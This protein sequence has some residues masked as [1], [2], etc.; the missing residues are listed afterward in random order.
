MRRASVTIKNASEKESGAM[1]IQIAPMAPMKKNVSVRVTNSS[2]LAK[3]VLLQRSYVI[4]KK[5]A[6]MD[7]TKGIVVSYLI[8]N[9]FLIFIRYNNYCLIFVFC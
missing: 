8:R 2:V 4:R 6:K 1:V 5:T 3:N 9:F 7:L